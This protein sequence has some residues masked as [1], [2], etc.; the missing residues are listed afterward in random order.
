MNNID[1]MPPNC[2]DC[3]YWEICEAP[4]VCSATEAKIRE[5]DGERK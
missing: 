2:H 3:P 5:K 4:Y 1:D